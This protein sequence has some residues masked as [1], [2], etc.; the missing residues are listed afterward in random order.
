MVQAVSHRPLVVG[1]LVWFE[2]L[3]FRICEGQNVT[4]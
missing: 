1:D 4:M 2:D 3:T